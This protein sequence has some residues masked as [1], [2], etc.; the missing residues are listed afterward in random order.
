MQAEMRLDSNELTAFFPSRLRISACFL[1]PG[2]WYH[3]AEKGGAMN[4]F[5][6]RSKSS[7]LGIWC[8]LLVILVLVVAILFAILGRSP[9]VLGVAIVGG[10]I[11]GVGLLIVL[12]KFFG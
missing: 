2:G 7:G 12:R 11:M 5:I 1:L 3:G 4:S 9:L 10:V 8:A 6:E